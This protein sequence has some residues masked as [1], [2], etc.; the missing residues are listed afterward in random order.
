MKK[1]LLTFTILLIL[2]NSALAQTYI[3]GVVPQQSPLVLHQKWMPVVNYLSK[4]TGLDIKF[5]TEKSISAFEKA[6]YSGE[7]DLAYMN[8]Y[9][10]VVANKEQG[11]DAALRRERKIRGILVSQKSST[12]KDINQDSFFIFP[13]PNAF[14]ATL[15][16]KYEL[17]KKFGIDL[18]KTTKFQY[19][20]SHDSVYKGVA[21]GIAQFGGGVQRTFNNFKD[22]QDKANIEVIYTTSAYPSHPVGFKK[23]FPATDREKI[24]KAFLTMPEYLLKSLSMK[25][26]ITTN[27]QEYDV[28]RDLSEN[29][30]IK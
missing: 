8:P 27:D 10:Y 5:K 23:N 6:L 19:V 1:R 11:Y 7:Y 29:L 20:N 14:A 24:V 30:A 18:T 12:I 16:M 4:Q 26:I 15:V 28:I 22:Q 25:K 21:R 13:S 3:L 2:A 17:K 9:H